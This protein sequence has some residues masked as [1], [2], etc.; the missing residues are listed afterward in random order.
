M[1]PSR[2]PSTQE[3]SFELTCS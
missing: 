3:T 2:K 1:L